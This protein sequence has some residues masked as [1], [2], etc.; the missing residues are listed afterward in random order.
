[1]SWKYPRRRKNDRFDDRDSDFFGEPFNFPFRSGFEDIDEMIES[2]FR[3]V[4]SLN[5]SAAENPNTIYYGYQ[6]AIGP[7]GKPNVR[8][9]GNVRPTRQGTFEVASRQPFVDVVL[10]EKEN[11]LKVVVEMPGVQKQD[12]SLETTEDSLSIR[13]ENRD[14][15]FDTQVP[16]NPKVEP[17]SA[18]ATYNNGILEVK[19]KLKSPPKS[20]GV[21]VKVD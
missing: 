20:K 21:A 10:D 4:N 19:L 8:E 13:T 9:F 17:S 5:E 11:E 12:I 7:D 18:K 15:K 3:T 14:R 6:V 16:L 2:M 1:M